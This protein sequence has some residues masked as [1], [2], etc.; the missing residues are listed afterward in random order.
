MAHSN[1]SKPLPQAVV[2]DNSRFLLH[3]RLAVSSTAASYL[4]QHATG[5]TK[6]F[7]HLLK[8]SASAPV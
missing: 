1:D 7:A 4:T 8:G 2:L 6:S 5:S 3:D